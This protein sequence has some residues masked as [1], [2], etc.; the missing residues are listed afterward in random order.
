MYK[1]LEAMVREAGQ[2]MLNQQKAAVHRKEGH[3]NFVTERDL[4]IQEFCASAC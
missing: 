2:M 3:F 4:Q 1:E